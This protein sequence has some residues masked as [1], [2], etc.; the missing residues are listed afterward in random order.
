MTLETMSLA[1]L[2]QWVATRESEEMPEE[3]G[4]YLGM[5]EKVYAWHQTMA[6]ENEIIKN[7]ISLYPDIIKND[8]LKAKRIYADA[9]NFFYMDAEITQEA[10][11]NVYAD[12]FDRLAT[13]VIKTARTA[14]DLAKAEKLWSKAAECRGVFAEKKEELPPEFYEQRYSIYTTK[15]KDL[16]LPETSRPEIIELIDALPIS[17][18]ENL[19]IKEDAAVLPRELLDW[20]NEASED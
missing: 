12:R 13:A 5:L 20:N 10:W 15:L 16:G 19:R 17:S 2:Q 1:T 14:S 4:I 8:R 9:V 3:L 18:A 11:A 6:L 7:L